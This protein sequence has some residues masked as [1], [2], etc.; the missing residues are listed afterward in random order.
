MEMDK[1]VTM[2]QN[3]RYCV[4]CVLP[5][6]KP[7][8][9]FD[10]EGV[11]SACHYYDTRPTIDWDSREKEFEILGFRAKLRGWELRCNV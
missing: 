2:K 8:L 11:C 10:N 6:T 5:D 9:S 1:G 4:K 7:D 3:I